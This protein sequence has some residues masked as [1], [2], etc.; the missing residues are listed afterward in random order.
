MDV[1][2]HI[3]TKADPLAPLRQSNQ[4]THEIP[5]SNHALV[6]G[7]FL[8][9][10]EAG[11]TNGDN[12]LCS[13]VVQHIDRLFIALFKLFFLTNEAGDLAAA[14]EQ[15]AHILL[16]QRIL[17]M[18]EHIFHP[19]GGISRYRTAG[20]KDIFGLLLLLYRLRC[21]IHA[22]TV[23]LTAFLFLSAVA[24]LQRLQRYKAAVLGSITVFH[25]LEVAPQI[26]FLGTFQRALAPLVTGIGDHAIH[27]FQTVFQIVPEQRFGTF[28]IVVEHDTFLHAQLAFTLSAPVG[29]PQ[30]FFFRISQSHLVKRVD[31]FSRIKLCHIHPL[32]R[33][34]RP[35]GRHLQ[36]GF[37]RPCI[38]QLTS[39]GQAFPAQETQHRF[40]RSAAG[41]HR[42]NGDH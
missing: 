16:P 10:L 24:L 13:H 21:R 12:N 42:L 7:S 19:F 4:V 23:F 41:R 25:G 39:F 35:V 33:N 11:R 6:F 36:L 27:I 5:V 40:C 18:A 31:A 20:N 9:N 1:K 34:L 29:L 28:R 3:R 38:L 22:G 37:V 15:R 14:L 2:H 30:G 17:Q 26:K 32:A 8:E